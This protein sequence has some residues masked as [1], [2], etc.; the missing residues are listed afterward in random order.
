MDGIGW[1][2]SA[3]QAARTRLDVATGNLAN[4][5]TDGFHKRAVRGFL[6][7]LGVRLR[8]F[9]DDAQGGLRYTGRLFDLAISGGGSFRLREPGGAVAAS[10][11]G[12]FFR[13]RFGR[14][15]DGSGR[16]VLGRHGALR[17]PDGSSIDASGAVRSNGVVVDRIALAPGASIRPGF[18]ESS[19]VDAISSMIDVLTAQRSF[20]TAQKVLSAIDQ[21]RERGV[22]QVAQVKA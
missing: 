20:E 7:A 15:A 8:I 2:S 14:L 11:G 13:D 19:N 17:V 3:M 5:S 22:T 12:S 1:A 21:T 18:L 9:S 6:T 10:R 16:V 4:G